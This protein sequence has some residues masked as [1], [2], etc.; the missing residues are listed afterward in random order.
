MTNKSLQG[1]RQWKCKNGHVLG[2]VIRQPINE[3]AQHF[4]ETR[5]ALFRHA[6]DPERVTDGNVVAI[7][8]GTTLDIKCNATGCDA[9]RSWFIGEIGIERSLISALDRP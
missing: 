1:L 7:I 5:L 9:T 8:V 4:C 3:G 2:I 6:V